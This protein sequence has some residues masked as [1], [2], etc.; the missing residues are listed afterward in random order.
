M[1][2]PLP[3]A[4]SHP[5]GGLVVEALPVHDAGQVLDPAYEAAV[6]RDGGHQLYHLQTGSRAPQYAERVQHQ[7]D[8]NGER[9]LPLHV[10]GQHCRAADT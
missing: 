8:R 9:R 4:H 5:D 1:L 6:V 3:L 2:V 7:A 10:L